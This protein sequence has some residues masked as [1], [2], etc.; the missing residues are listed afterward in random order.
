MGNLTELTVYE[1]TGHRMILQN[2]GLTENLRVVRK[3]LNVHL[4]FSCSA[5]ASGTGPL[6]A[7]SEVADTR[8]LLEEFEEF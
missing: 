6:L 1:N 4:I 8:L 2:F 5:A 7:L 3:F